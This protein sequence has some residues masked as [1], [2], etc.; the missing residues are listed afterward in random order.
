[1]KLKRNKLFNKKTLFPM[2]KISNGLTK[3]KDIRF[4]KR[5]NTN[6]KIMKFKVKHFNKQ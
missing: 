2:K 6:H 4:S 3:A 1:M 5:M